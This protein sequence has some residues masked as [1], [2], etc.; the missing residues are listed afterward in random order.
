MKQY[1]FR[2][3]ISNIFMKE[4]QHEKDR[5]IYGFNNYCRT[6]YIVMRHLKKKSFIRLTSN[7]IVL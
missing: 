5:D 6:N 7:N 2:V 1:Q 3:N 4:I